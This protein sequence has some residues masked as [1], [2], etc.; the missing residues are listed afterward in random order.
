MLKMAKDADCAWL[1]AYDDY[2][3]HLAEEYGE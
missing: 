3:Q 2:F 1:K